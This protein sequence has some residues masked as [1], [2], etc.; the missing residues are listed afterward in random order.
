MNK[1]LNAIFCMFLIIL[2]P[3]SV[4][5]LNVDQYAADEDLLDDL[6]DMDCILI[7]DEELIFWNPINE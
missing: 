2:M 6:D 1:K 7:F 3:L 5:D 4:A